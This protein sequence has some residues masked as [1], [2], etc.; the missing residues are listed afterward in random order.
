MT[1]Q[2]EGKKIELESLGDWYKEAQTTP[3]EEVVT[4]KDRL[5]YVEEG[6]QFLE[7]NQA[8]I[9]MPDGEFDKYITVRD[10]WVFIRGWLGTEDDSTDKVRRKAFNKRLRN[11]DVA[12]RFLVNALSM[13][14]RILILDPMTEQIFTYFRKGTRKTPHRIATADAFRLTLHVCWLVHNGYLEPQDSIDQEFLESTYRIITNP[15]NAGSSDIFTVREKTPR[16]LSNL[17]NKI[18]DPFRMLPALVQ[19]RWV[20]ISK[21]TFYDDGYY[22]YLCAPSWMFG[23]EFE[24]DSNKVQWNAYDGRRVDFWSYYRLQNLTSEP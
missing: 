21:P 5:S 17:R 19:D 23:M 22:H 16:T 7:K 18:H 15:A 24:P 10:S 9:V 1:P 11:D 2:S 14:S 6:L 20:I 3:G 4:K 13:R 12:I 8:K